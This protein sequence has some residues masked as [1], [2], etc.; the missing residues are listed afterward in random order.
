MCALLNFRKY[1]LQFPHFIGVYTESPRRHVTCPKSQREL[2]AKGK[3]ESLCQLGIITVVP[4]FPE[5]SLSTVSIIHSQPQSENM[6]GK[7]QK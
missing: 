3:T 7:F 4:P 6:N 2:Q 1:L 5:V